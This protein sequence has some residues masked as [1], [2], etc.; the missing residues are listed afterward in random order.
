MLDVIFVGNFPQPPLNHSREK[1]WPPS[2]LKIIIAHPL[3]KLW[4]LPYTSYYCKLFWFANIHYFLW[5][6]IYVD[7][8][9]ERNKIKGF[10]IR[11]QPSTVNNKNGLTSSIIYCKR[12]NSSQSSDI[13]REFPSA[14]TNN[15]FRGFRLVIMFTQDGIAFCGHDRKP[16][17]TRLLFTH[18]NG[19]LTARCL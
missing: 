2:P 6:R 17:L 8:K 10:S 4:M 13:R 19:E 18:K 15:A 14:R 3:G 5:G 1:E 11:S 16:Y 7:K 12:N 9:Y